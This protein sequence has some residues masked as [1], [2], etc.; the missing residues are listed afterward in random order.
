MVDVLTGG[1]E[2]RVYLLPTEMQRIRP[3]YRP[4]LHKGEIGI[5]TVIFPL[6]LRKLPTRIHHKESILQVQRVSD[7]MFPQQHLLLVL[8]QLLRNT[9]EIYDAVIDGLLV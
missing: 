4:M 7:S 8:A 3:V 2:R 5:R 1:L 6:P 9:V